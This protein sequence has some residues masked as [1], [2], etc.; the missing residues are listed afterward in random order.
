MKYTVDTVLCETCGDA[1]TFT[2][3]KRCNDCR[4]VEMRLAG[5]LGRGGRNATVFVTT[6]L[7][8]LAMQRRGGAP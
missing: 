1:T 7:A 5:Y 4:E 6:A 2:A 8:N 3:T